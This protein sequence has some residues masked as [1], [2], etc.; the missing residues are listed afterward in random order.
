MTSKGSNT[1]A[2]RRGEGQ[3]IPMETGASSAVVMLTHN[4]VHLL[5]QCV[6]NVLGRVSSDVVEIV[7][8]D[9]ASTD[10]TPSYLR[11]LPPNPRRRIIHSGTNLGHNAY[12]RAIAL[13]TAPYIIELDDDVIEAPEGWDR[14]LLEAYRALPDVGYLGANLMDD[15]LDATAR[16]MYGA[17]RARYTYEEVN[18]YRLKVGPVGGWCT[19]TDR[20][21][22]ERVGGFGQDKRWVFW[23]EDAAYVRKLEALGLRAANLDSLLVHHAGGR[24]YSPLVPAKIEWWQHYN[25]RRRRRNAIKRAILML[26]GARLI[27]DRFRLFVDPRLDKGGA[28]AFD[29]YDK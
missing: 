24:N 2:S 16:V 28:S 3:V 20:A 1:T 9:N 4:R 17:N 8:W 10:G 29:K 23:L 15:P 7:I 6:E 14:A 5:Q 22:Y 11:N 21:L 26:P 19:I 18:G 27:N 12:S 25:R 13:T